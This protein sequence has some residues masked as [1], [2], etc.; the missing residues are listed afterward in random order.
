M[1]AQRAFNGF[2]SL[3][4]L[5]MMLDYAINDGPALLM[6]RRRSSTRAAIGHTS[7]IRAVSCQRCCVSVKSAWRRFGNPGTGGCHGRRELAQPKSV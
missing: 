1:G 4:G 5:K 2:D 7:C 3:G 6:P